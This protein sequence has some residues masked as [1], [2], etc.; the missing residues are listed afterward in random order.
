MYVCVHIVLSVCVH[1]VLS[2]RVCTHSFECLVHTDVYLE[3]AVHHGFK[4]IV[5]FAIIVTW[6]FKLVP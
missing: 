6:S 4:I 5:V 3:P 1:I 2:V